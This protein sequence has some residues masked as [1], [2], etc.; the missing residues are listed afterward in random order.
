[1]Y[2]GLAL[3]KKPPGGDPVFYLQ[4]AHARICSILKMT[5]KEGLKLSTE[6]LDLLTT[7]EEQLLLKK[8]HS[9]KDEIEY[10]TELFE[11]HR[12]CVYLEDL[13]ALFHRFY[14]VCRII[15]SEKKLAEVRI[16]L[17]TAT[18]AVLKNGLT[19]LGVSAPERM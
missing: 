5:E 9:F 10:A 13:A 16:A 8:L 18:R 17:V 4:Y 6:N 19:L 3:S 15:G 2:F 14:T 12:I 1:M 7:N 11:A